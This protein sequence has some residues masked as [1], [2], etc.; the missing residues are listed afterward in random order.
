MVVVS[1]YMIDEIQEG[2]VILSQTPL[3]GFFSLPSDLKPR[4]Y[5]LFGAGI[6]ITPL[7]SIVKTVLYVSPKDKSSSDIFQSQ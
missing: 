6:G 2:S 3:G 7:F 1:N 4:E 5:I